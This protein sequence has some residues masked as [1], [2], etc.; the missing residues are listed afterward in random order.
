MLT[1][2]TLQTQLHP[3]IQ[4]LSEAILNIWGS[5]LTLAPYDL[6]ADL[7]YVEGRLDGEKLQIENRC[8]QGDPFRK[9]HLELARA[10][11]SLDILHCVMFPQP[12]YPL[13]MFGCDIVAGRGQVS[14][15]IVDL[16][17]VTPSLP[18]PYLQALETLGSHLALFR[19]RRELPPWG[20]IFSPYCLF[21]RPSDP[22]EEDQFLA[23]ASRYLDIHCQLARQIP[24]QTD[25]KQI[26]SNYQGQQRYCSQQQQNDRTRRVLERAFGP[27]WAE[28]YMST[29]LFDL[30]PS[31]YES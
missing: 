21:I 25:A 23:L 4:R 15:A 29:V 11:H 27:E 1:A 20:S 24:P 2:P 30:P 6:P 31:P 16:S 17:P 22:R 5:T 12:Q 10:G 18:E 8:Y 3:L 7:G 13:P 9:L 14:A 28:R 26:L 19:Q